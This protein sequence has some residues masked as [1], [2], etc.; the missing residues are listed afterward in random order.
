MKHHVGQTGNGV[1][2]YVNLIGSEASKQISQQPYLLGLITEALQQIKPRGQEVNVERDMGRNIGYSFV[3]RTSD[4]DSIFYAQILKDTTYTRFIKNG[5]P[6]STSYLT[7]QLRLDS[8][9][10]E[11]E[12]HN[13]YVGRLSPPRPGSTDETAES[14]TYWANH[15]FIVGNQTL[16]LRTVTK[17]CPY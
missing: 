15:A 9:D 10:N 16:Q 8:E 5:K 14:K 3:V 17:V 7:L 4:T 13:V 2:V 6:K 12:L 1:A 11:Y